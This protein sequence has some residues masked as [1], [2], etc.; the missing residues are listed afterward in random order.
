MNR[1]LAWCLSGLLVI[2]AL[3]SQAGE[4]ANPWIRGIFTGRSPRPVALTESLAWQKA[5]ELA[6]LTPGAF[7]LVGSGLSMQ[8]LYASGTI[9][10]LQVQAYENLAPGQTAL[11]RSHA[12]K[13]VAH[14]LIAKTRDGWRV[15]GLNNRIHDMEPL[16]RDNLVGVV[17]G[18]FSPQLEL[19]PVRI[20]ALD[21]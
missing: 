13:I 10:V 1:R 8:P 3:A 18:A 5:S 7:V 9:L 17:I 20:A 19:R 21:R 2:S 6:E 12:H 15:A 14:V 4:L 16:S 11:Y